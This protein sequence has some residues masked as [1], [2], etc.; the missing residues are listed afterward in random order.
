MSQVSL[1]YELDEGAHG[2]AATW[3]GSSRSRP[4][5]VAKALH[6]HARILRGSEEERVF[7]FTG[8][9][10]RDRSVYLSLIQPTVA[11]QVHLGELCVDQSTASSVARYTTFV[12]SYRVAG[13]S[14]GCPFADVADGAS[15]GYNRVP[16]QL[17]LEV[18]CF[19]TIW[20]E[21]DICIYVH[22]LA[23][24]YSIRRILM[25]ACVLTSHR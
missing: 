19:Y 1:I 3:W 16:R 14:R 24:I 9:L 6:L 4:L 21:I 8:S 13:Y 10:E 15:T 11:T 5:P 22:W 7:G 25:C 20:E 23:T 2:L 17:S 12:V 18:M